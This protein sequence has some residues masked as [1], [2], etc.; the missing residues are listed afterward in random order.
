LRGVDQT[1]AEKAQ[2]SFARFRSLARKPVAVAKK[3]MD[4]QRAKKAPA[5]GAKHP[6]G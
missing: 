6:R 5:T 3:E 2:E 4:E 1:V